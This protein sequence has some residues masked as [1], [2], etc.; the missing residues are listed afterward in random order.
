MGQI[1]SDINASRLNEHRRNKKLRLTH[2]ERKAFSRH[3]DLLVSLTFWNYVV[4]L[5]KDLL[6]LHD[7][8]ST[9]EIDAEAD[10]ISKTVI[11]TIYRIS[12]EYNVAMSALINNLL[13]RVGA[14]KKGYCYHYVNDLRSALSKY[15]LKYFDVVWGE[16]WGKTIRE[17]NA[18]VI[19]AHNK[20]FNDGITIDSWRT[21]GKPFWTSVRGDRF[22]WVEL[23]EVV[24]QD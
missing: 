22:P 24:I 12:Q 1:L 13:I 6:A 16:S 11:E 18:L 9:A 4:G 3:E 19:K 17:N 23:K 15:D 8:N 5:K 14:K 21:N 2:K 7:K 20:N 10:D